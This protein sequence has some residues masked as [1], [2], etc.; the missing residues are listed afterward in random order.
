M[1]RQ[2]ESTSQ[3]NERIH[4]PS[5]AGFTLLEVLVVIA[6]ISI[7]AMVATPI[8]QSY[9]IRAKVG[10]E[11]KQ[12]ADLKQ[13]VT[14]Q[15]MIEGVWVTSN[16]EAGGKPPQHYGGQYVESV[17]I[18]DNPVPGSILVTYDSVALPVLGANNTLVFRPD[19]SGSGG[20]EWICDTGT[21]VDKYRPN[22]CKL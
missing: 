16:E 5:D 14:E 17:E 22:Q 4:A 1:N 7:I 12:I 8:Y 6:I 20:F 19:T 18:T 3:R 11:L 2:S 9:S 13:R 21:M 10:A 15:F